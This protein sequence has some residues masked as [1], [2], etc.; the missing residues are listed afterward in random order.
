[1]VRSRLEG[2]W[3]DPSGGSLLPTQGFVADLKLLV[4]GDSPVVEPEL[5]PEDNPT[6]SEGWWI[7]GKLELRPILLLSHICAINDC[8]L[9]ASV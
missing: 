2:D 9:A 1:V 5:A 7:V 8:S 3:K 4:T 6:A